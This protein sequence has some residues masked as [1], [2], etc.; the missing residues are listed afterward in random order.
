[1]NLIL[2][3]IYSNALKIAQ[4]HL[5]TVRK[6]HRRFSD[7]HLFTFSDPIEVGGSPIRGKDGGIELA[8]DH[9]CRRP[10]IVGNF[11]HGDT[12]RSFCVLGEHVYTMP[13]NVQRRVCHSTE[14]KI[15]RFSPSPRL[16]FCGPA[17]DRRVRGWALLHAPG[18]R[19]GR[20]DAALRALAFATGRAGLDAVGGGSPFSSLRAES[21]AIHGLSSPHTA[22]SVHGLPRPLRASQ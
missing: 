10:D 1:M 6:F 19:R 8:Y 13:R 16:T 5:N 20:V 7:E 15:I 9:Y 18:L 12:I 2:S 17:E 21:V 11:A 14:D 4:R 22:T 3:E